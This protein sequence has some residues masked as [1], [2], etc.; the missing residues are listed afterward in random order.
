MVIVRRVR[1]RR[2]QERAPRIIVNG[3]QIER[4]IWPY[5]DVRTDDV[6]HQIEHVVGGWRVAR[7]DQGRPG[8]IVVSVDDPRNGAGQ[9]TIVIPVSMERRG[10]RGADDAA[11]VHGPA[12]RVTTARWGRHR[13]N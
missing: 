3:E 12:L 5:P 6:P 10:T 9:R 13:R 7:V 1:V 8:Q 4:T 11:L 2:V